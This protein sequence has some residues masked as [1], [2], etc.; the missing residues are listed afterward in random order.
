MPRL[1]LFEIT[2]IQ[3]IFY[4]GLHLMDEYIG[5]LCSLV[6]GVIALAI[7]LVSLITEMVER[8]K[9]PGWYYKLMLITTI[10]PILVLLVFKFV[11]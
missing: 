2:L 3:L 8:S 7:Y 10:T 9:V 5:F 1:S 11:L 4:I 6:I